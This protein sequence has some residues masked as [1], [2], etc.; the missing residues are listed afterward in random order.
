MDRQRAGA[1]YD[2][3]QAEVRG[4]ISEYS[5]QEIYIHSVTAVTQDRLYSKNDQTSTT[6]CVVNV[7]FCTQ[8]GQ[9]LV[10][11]MSGRVSHFYIFLSK[12]K[13]WA[14]FLLGIVS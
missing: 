5:F 10:W 13:G 4:E 9:C 7:L 6:P 3:R 12:Q 8:C 14:V 1:H 11:S 2:Q